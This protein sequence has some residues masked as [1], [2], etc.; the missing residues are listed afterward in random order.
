MKEKL[1]EKLQSSLNNLLK[2]DTSQ[3]KKLQNLAGRIAVIHISPI[4]LTLNCLFTHDGIDF[5]A[6]LYAEPNV[7]ISGSPLAF[8]AMNLSENKL[9]DIFAGKIKI[10]GDV[11]TAQKVQDLLQGIEF[12]WEEYLSRYTG[13][14]IA[15]HIGNIGKKFMRFGQRFINTSQQN[16]REYLQEEIKLLPTRIEVEDFLDNIDTLRSDIDRLEAKINLLEK[17]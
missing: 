5:L 10:T 3:Q 14:P 1:K 8:L 17:S 16:I 15:Y 2:N 7:T 12:D 6:N 4:N 11:D 9:A 13:D